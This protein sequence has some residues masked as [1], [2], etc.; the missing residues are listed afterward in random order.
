MPDTIH[1]DGELNFNWSLRDIRVVV[2]DMMVAYLLKDAIKGSWVHTNLPSELV[3]I[4]VAP[5]GEEMNLRTSCDLA[6]G[7]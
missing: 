6:F 3:D 7:A 2:E 4:T 1:E 5:R